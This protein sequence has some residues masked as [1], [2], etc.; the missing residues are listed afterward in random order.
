MHRDVLERNLQR[1]VRCYLLWELFLNKYSKW[2][3]LISPLS[4][5]FD[6]NLSLTLRILFAHFIQSEPLKSEI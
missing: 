5:Y 2:S 6:K 1:G 4:T 3:L